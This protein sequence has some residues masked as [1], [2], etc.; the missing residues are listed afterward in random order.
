MR[1][2]MSMKRRRNLLLL[3]GL[4]VLLVWSW[5]VF[6]R[7]ADSMPGRTE[8]IRSDQGS[9]IELPLDE[10]PPLR[11]YLEGE[12]A[13]EEELERT[14]F[15]EIE[16]GETD[17]LGVVKYGCGNKSCSL[18]LVRSGDSGTSSIELPRGLYVDSR[19]DRGRILLRLAYPE[20]N[21]VV[22]HL[23]L[24]IDYRTMTMLS[25]GDEGDQ[26]QLLSS[27]AWPVMD[28]G[29]DGTDRIWIETAAADIGDYEEL[30]QW[31]ANENRE[32]RIRKLHLHF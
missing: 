20:G 4:A 1:M 26:R 27:P 2:K 28:Y 5:S 25:Y 17:R 21:R 3:L 12:G 15:S 11:A 9:G 30:E 6:G 16:T 18:L 29:W 7:E 24:P 22:R 23:I 10:L 32:L 19:V 8:V 31:F 13:A 14:A